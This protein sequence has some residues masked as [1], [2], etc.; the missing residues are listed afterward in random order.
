MIA[1]ESARQARWWALILADPKRGQRH[2]MWAFVS[3][4]LPQEQRL[5]S[6]LFQRCRFW[7]LGNV[8]VMD[9]TNQRLCLVSGPCR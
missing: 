3:T 7:R 9:C 6:A 5:E 8:L 1:E 4:A 2:C